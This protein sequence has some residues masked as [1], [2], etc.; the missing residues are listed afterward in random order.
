MNFSNI[1]NTLGGKLR[2]HTTKGPNGGHLLTGTVNCVN[3]KD[4]E[5]RGH[6]GAAAGRARSRARSAALPLAASLKRDPPDPGTPKP[7]VP[8]SV[9]AVYKLSPRSTCFGGLMELTGSGTR[10]KVKANG[11]TLGTVAYNEGTGA[12]AGDVKC[13][14]GG[15]VRFRAVA[16]DRNLNNITLIPLDVA[17]PAKPPRR[18]RAEGDGEAGAHDA[19]GAAA[20]G[21]EVHRHQAARVV[22]QARRRVPHRRGDRACSSPGSS[23]SWPRGSASRA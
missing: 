13:T 11:K 2:L 10:Y 3:G 15:T 14:R 1:Q 21:R 8:G 6:R 18:R 17:T 4:A 19:L 12:L 23:A 5:F 22:R 20:R 16:V 9:A 7:R